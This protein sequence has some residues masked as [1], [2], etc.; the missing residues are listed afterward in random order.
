MFC[1]PLVFSEADEEAE[2][3]EEG[4]EGYDLAGCGWGGFGED[5]DEVD[6]DDAEEPGGDG[7]HDHGE[8]GIARGGEDAGEDPGDAVEDEKDP[9]PGEAGAG[10]VKDGFK[11][12]WILGGVMGKEDIE[13]GIR[14]E[15]EGDGDYG[16]EDE[17][18]FEG[19]VDGFADH[20]GAF[21]AEKVSGGGDDGFLHAVACEG[22]EDE[23]GLCDSEDGDM[24]FADSSD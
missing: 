22:E 21:A 17:V 24:V 19:G 7:V 1:A 20:A 6:G 5:D 10:V 23:D 14:E 13:E 4:V 8:F 18:E 2:A 15:E 16:D 9:D 11:V 3:V 12:G